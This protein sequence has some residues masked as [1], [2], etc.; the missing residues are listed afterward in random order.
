MMQGLTSVSTFLGLY[1]R[2][3]WINLFT[4]DH[5]AENVPEAPAV[6]KMAIFL[7]KVVDNIFKQ[8]LKHKWQTINFCQ[9]I[10]MEL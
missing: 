1:L 2:Q 3:G 6:S 4:T 10:N 5:F 8:S 9:N 7:H